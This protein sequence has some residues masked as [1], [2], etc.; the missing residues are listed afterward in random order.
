MTV[1]LLPKIGHQIGQQV[2]SFLKAL[3]LI[4]FVMLNF[5]PGDSDDPNR[6][7]NC[8]ASGAMKPPALLQ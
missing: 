4:D 7:D 3:D 2:L 6:Y 5:P 1:L 8:V